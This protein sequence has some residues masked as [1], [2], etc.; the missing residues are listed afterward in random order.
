[1]DIYD[2][3]AVTYTQGP[4]P[5]FSLQMADALPYVLTRLGQ[6][7][8]TVLDVACGEGAFA[9]QMAREGYA[10]TGVDRSPRML[11]IARERARLAEVEVRFLEQDLRALALDERY[12][13]VTCW[14]D[15]LNYLLTADDLARAFCGVGAALAEGGLFL[16]DMN[17]LYGLA[18]EWQ[19]NACY[20]Q[21]D[22]PDILEI[23]RPTYDH[24]TAIAT[25][26]I[27][28]FLRDGGHW[29]RYTEVHR[30][31]GY[32]LAEIRRCLAEAGL[33][34]VGCWGSLREYTPPT[35]QSG[36]VWFAARADNKAA[37]SRRTP[38]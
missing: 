19:R 17:T 14:F 7:P 12:D 18:V 13:L 24:E 2:T 31:R 5:R 32:R 28:G 38:E 36:R 22:T 37:P 6:R 9:V 25:L 20:V 27:D 34:E 11:E 16:F 21:Q 10:V 33:E 15:S 4:Y 35:P 3:F 29:L 26:Q 8:R 30:E 23:H 1:V